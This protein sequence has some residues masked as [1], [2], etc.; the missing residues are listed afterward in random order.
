MAANFVQFELVGARGFEAAL[1][2]TSDE[3]RRQCERVCRDTAFRVMHLAKA[4][5]PRDKGDL[6]R[7]IAAKGK[8]LNWRVGLLD[9]A[10]PSRGGDSAHQ[11]PWVYGV[12]Y[13]YGFVTK[14][15][16][17][18]PFMRPAAEAEADRHYE[19]LTVAVNGGLAQAA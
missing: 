2:R 7:V 3:I 4:L 5:A 12:W 6:I 16:A 18:R 1:E 10:F 19:A 14:K 13:E 8:G 17:A 15:I 11:H 9:S